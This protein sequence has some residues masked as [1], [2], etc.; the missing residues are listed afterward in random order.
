V[1]LLI[2]YLSPGELPKAANWG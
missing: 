2:G 1:A